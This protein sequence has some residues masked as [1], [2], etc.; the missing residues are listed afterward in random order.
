[1]RVLAVETSTLAG[2]VALLDDDRLVAECLLDVR[3]THSER[4][5][6]TIDRMLGDAGWTSRD[7]G[8]LAVAIGPGSFTGLRIGLS[9]VKGLAVALSLPIAAVPTLDA[10]AAALPFAGLPV[11][12]VLEARKGEVYTSLYRWK[13]AEMR[14]EWDYLA[15]TPADLAGRLAEPVIVLGDGAAAVESPYAEIV[16]AHRRLPSPGSVAWLG[17]QRLRAGDTVGAADLAPLYLRPP[18]AELKR[19]GHPHR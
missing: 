3:V 8:G 13:G 15:L 17:A 4:L 19:R 5:L 10:L 6:A 2:G 12:P 7:L 9:T 11:C 16:P 18:E 14:R 1:M